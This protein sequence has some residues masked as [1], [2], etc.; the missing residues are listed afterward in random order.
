MRARRSAYR[1]SANYRS[2]LNG[3]PFHELN[4]MIDLDTVPANTGPL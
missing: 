2:E 4:S 3:C 1:F